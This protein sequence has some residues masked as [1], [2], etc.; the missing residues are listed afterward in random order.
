MDGE[1][2]L[3]NHSYNDM[4]EAALLA[5]LARLEDLSGC[6]MLF[7]TIKINCGSGKTFGI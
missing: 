3:A 4:D 2:A 5:E 1:N 6:S 7:Q